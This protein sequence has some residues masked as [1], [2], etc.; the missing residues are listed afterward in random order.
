MNTIYR[1]E[2]PVTWQGL[3][4]RK[5]GSFNPFIKT[6]TN[7]IARDLPMGFDPEFKVDGLDWI[8]GCDNLPDMKNW[9]SAQDLTELYGF[10]YD[11]YE[12]K[13]ERYRT[14]NGHAAFA[15]E[16]ILESQKLDLS[17][18]KKIY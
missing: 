1:V 3:W 11:L 16:H 18:L 17:L 14:V 15:R 10:G 13:V 5:D 7:A 9:F 4:Y 6:L 12:F 8:S 2:N